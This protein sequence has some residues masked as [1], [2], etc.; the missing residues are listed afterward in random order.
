MVQGKIETLYNKYELKEGNIIKL[1]NFYLKLKRL[2]IKEN[3]GENIKFINP[4]FHHLYNSVETSNINSTNNISFQKSNHKANLKLNLKE[5]EQNLLDDKADKEELNL[6]RNIKPITLNKTEREKTCR[7][8]YSGDA[9]EDN[10]LIHPCSCIGSMKYIH[11]KCLKIWL[12]KNYYK[13]EYKIG[14]IRRYRYKEPECELCKS[15]FPEIIYYKGKDYSFLDANGEFNDYAVFESIPNDDNNHKIIYIFSLDKKNQILKLGRAMDNHLIIQDNSISR[16]HCGLLVLNNKLFIE[17]MNSKFGTL[18][19]VQSQT[20][21]LGENQN[22]YFQIGNNFIIGKVYNPSLNSLFSCCSV[23]N[24]DKIFD[25]YYKQNIIKTE[26]DNKNNNNIY[27]NSKVSS[28][29]EDD[30]ENIKE[31]E[32]KIKVSDF[33]YINKI[34]NERPKKNKTNNIATNANI[35]LPMNDIRIIPEN[36]N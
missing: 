24:Q 20:I 23:D 15:K 25:F 34:K 9:D 7:I 14:L 8:C 5:Y 19:F 2:K 13:L 33:V 17:D 16:N 30:G 35:I 29:N 27:M 10:P 22:F 28:D 18:I 6:N 3:K 36:E 1:G 32:N 26:E 12:A 11:Y 31:K 21:Q 4:K